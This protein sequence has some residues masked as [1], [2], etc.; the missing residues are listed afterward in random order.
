MNGL[1][2]VANFEFTQQPSVHITE[3]AFFGAVFLCPTVCKTRGL[4]NEDF[5][6]TW[7][8]LLSRTCRLRLL[9][10]GNL[11]VCLFG[12][13]EVSLRN[14]MREGATDDELMAV[15]SAA[16]NRKKA[17]HAGMFELSA[18]KNRAMIKLVDR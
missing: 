17:A 12:S 11:K 16:V 18:T 3:F 5:E 7:A 2:F 4:C 15:I 6:T 10:D 14:A 1:V 13:N 8:T 9:A